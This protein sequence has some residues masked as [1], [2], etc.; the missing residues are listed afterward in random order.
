MSVIDTL[1]LGPTTEE[2]T[3]AFISQWV[4]YEVSG[5]NFTVQILPQSSPVA[6][7]WDRFITYQ[8]SPMSTGAEYGGTLAM[9]AYWDGPI[10]NRRKVLSALAK[11]PKMNG[12]L[13]QAQ[14][15]LAVAFKNGR[16][17]LEGDPD[18]EQ[19]YIV[20]ETS[21]EVNRAREV[22]SEFDQGWWLENMDDASGNLSVVL[23]LV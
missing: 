10:R 11:N 16:L 14:N 13:V 7:Y 23:D 12:V 2:S 20:V 6:S 21:L 5:S 19:L 18:G 3:F 4:S 1:K 8:G 15:R 22:L 17:I 9:D